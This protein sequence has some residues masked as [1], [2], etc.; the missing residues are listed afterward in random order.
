MEGLGI[1]EAK[2]APIV[3]IVPHHRR[4]CLPYQIVCLPL[5]ITVGGN[6]QVLGIMNLLLSEFKIIL[7]CGYSL[8]HREFPNHISTGQ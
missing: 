5:A 6:V 2:A 4:V 8:V 7:V 1:K 3:V